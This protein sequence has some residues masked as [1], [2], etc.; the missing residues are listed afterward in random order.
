MELISVDNLGEL[1]DTTTDSVGDLS[2]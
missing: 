1:R 2:R